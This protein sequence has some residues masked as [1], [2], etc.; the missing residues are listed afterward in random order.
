MPLEGLVRVVF[1]ISLL[2]NL[3]G[4]RPNVIT[5]GSSASCCYDGNLI[6]VHTDFAHFRTALVNFGCA[7]LSPQGNEFEFSIALFSSAHREFLS[8][9]K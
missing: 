6:F 1:A 8:H 5:S 7:G 2:A 4:F 9:C 3:P